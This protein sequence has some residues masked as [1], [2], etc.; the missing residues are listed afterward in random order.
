MHRTQNS[1]LIYCEIIN[2]FLR[3]L[4][5]ETYDSV[6]KTVTHFNRNTKN[7]AFFTTRI[8]R[9][10]RAHALFE[11][12]A[13]GSAKKQP[14]PGETNTTTAPLVSSWLSFFR[15]WFNH[16]PLPNYPAF[17]F[18]VTEKQLQFA[19]LTLTFRAFK[20]IKPVFTIW[21]TP[22]KAIRGMIISLPLRSTAM[23]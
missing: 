19:S 20:K 18:F 22:R 11:T 7:I 21:S 23:S 3:I 4:F 15:D 8:A 17:F 14:Q 2:V 16:A 10:H 9:F 12:M 13:K 6:V 1:R 5:I